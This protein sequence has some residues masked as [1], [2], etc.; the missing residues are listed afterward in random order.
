MNR[1]DRSLLGTDQLTPAQINSYLKLAQRM[2][3]RKAPPLLRGKR[4]VLLFYEAS[5]RTRTRFR[6]RK[7]A[8][9]AK[10]I[11]IGG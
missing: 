9:E 7:S 1:R 10:T 4:V 8:V 2:D 5:T 6:V 11:D 3:P